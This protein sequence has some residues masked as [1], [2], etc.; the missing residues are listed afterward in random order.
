MSRRTETSQV[1]ANPSGTF[2]EDRYALAQ[3]TRQ[4]GRLVEIDT[5]LKPGADGRIS[6]KATTIGLEFS[7]GGAGPLATIT[8]D[9]R[10]M[11]LSW[12]TALP[13]PHVAGDTATYPEVLPGVDLKLRAGNSGFGQLLVVKSA[14][15][16]ANPA[17]KAVSLKLASDGVAVSADGHGNLTAVNP[18][19]QEVFTA[20]TPL[21]WDSSAKK[22]K[23]AHRSS[24]RLAAAA[25]SADAPPPNDEFEPRHGAQ[26]AAMP[27]AVA[28]GKVTLTPDQA[29]LRGEKTTYPVYLDPAVSGGREAWAIAYKKYPDAHYFNGAGWRNADGSTGTSLA[30]VGYENQDNGLGRSFFRMDSNNLWNTRKQVIKSTFRIK[31]TWSWSCTPRTVETWLTDPVYPT[32]SWKNQPTWERRLDSVNDSKGWG[33]GCPAGNLAFDV[34]SAAKDAAARKWPNITLGMRVPQSLEDSRDE[35]AWKK[36]DAKTAALSTEYNTLPNAPTSLDTAP[37]SGGCKT[38]GPYVSVGNTDVHLTARVGDPDGGT[39][40][41]QF[42]LWATGHHPNDDPKAVMIVNQT[43]SATSGTVAR[44]KIPK[45]TLAKHI[46]AAGGHFSW[47]V[48]AEDGRTSSDWTPAS[49]KPG[50][51]FVFDPTRPSTPPGIAST[52]YPDGSDG[53][54]QTTGRAR[55]QGLFALTNGGVG[56]VTKYEYWTDWDPT[57]R[58]ATPQNPSDPADRAEI[59]LTPPAAGSHGLYVRS[60]DGAGNLSDQALHLFYADSPATPDKPGDLNGDG[61]ADFYGLRTDGS[62]RLYPGQGNGYVG[63]A[64]AA[65]NTDLNGASITHRGD[66]TDDGF[67]DLVAAVPGSGGKTLQIFP[68]N[69]VGYACSARDEQADGHSRS[70]L[71]EQQELDVYDPANNHWANADQIL[72]I[73]DVDG[74]LDTDGDGAVDVEGHPDLL[75]KEGDLLWLYYGSDSFYLD[76]TSPPVLVG[77]GGWSE[78]D[79][80]APG[81]RN[82]DNHVD[83]VARRKIEGELRIYTGTGPAGEGLGSGHTVIGTGWTAGRRPLITAA[84]DANGD[85][86]PDLWATGSDAN[87]YIH[88]DLEG[89]AGTQIGAGGWNAFQAIS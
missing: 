45:A 70:C 67:E 25:G 6:P 74:P 52:D 79:L 56:D 53:W 12:P 21:M 86:R 1:F 65:G 81:D 23:P 22:E 11:S 88:H 68:N 41:A 85:G 77:N 63:T 59:P 24:A 83:L 66:W 60:R 69:G 54:P 58:T 35:Y 30:R 82:A 17:L 51:Q 29:L 46:P 44:L 76:G 48:Q 10:S 43:V 18:A 64:T 37:S 61:Y 89:G 62:L 34:T 42:N 15:A 16:A 27:L 84:P 32:T 57:V 20:P 8:R 28:G 26:E 55:T 38:S 75:V 5:T 31:N 19:G 4:D 47:K 87:L 72:A 71:Y 9:G 78:F 80:A 33:S 49:G 40:K 36:F 3:W 50:C 14:E 73:G 39:V 2:T 7:G 13:K